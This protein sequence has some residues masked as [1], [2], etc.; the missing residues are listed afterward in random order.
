[1][2]DLKKIFKNIHFLGHN[3]GSDWQKL[4]MIFSVIIL[5]IGVWSIYSFIQIRGEVFVLDTKSAS[6][7]VEAEN[8]ERELQAVLSVYTQKEDVYKKL[9]AGIVVRPAATTTSSTTT[10]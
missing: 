7:R 10:P 5:L 4:F 9:Q 3:P 2:N 8:K 1:M 6:A